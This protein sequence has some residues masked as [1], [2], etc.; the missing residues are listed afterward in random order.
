MELAKENY[1]DQRGL[2]ELDLL[3]QDVRYT[4]R[5][6]GRNPGFTAVVVLTLALGIG[7]NTA[8]FSATNA[9]MLRLLPVRDA[10]RLVYLNTTESISSQS[11]D[12]DTSLTEYIFEQI[13]RPAGC[14]LRCH[15]IRPS[16][17]SESSGSLR[18]GARRIVR[19]DGERKF[20]FRAGRLGPDGPGVPVG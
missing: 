15:W 3:F 7:A 20:L 14:V 13:A 10:G 8:V 2:P 11:G 17:V 16:F 12:G 18:P 5:Q 19:R 4:T 9:V 6:F 1:R